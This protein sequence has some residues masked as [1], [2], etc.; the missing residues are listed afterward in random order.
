MSGSSWPGKRWS[1]SDSETARQIRRSRRR[2]PW[3]DRASGPGSDGPRGF[4]HRQRYRRQL[5]RQIVEHPART[6][7]AVTRSVRNRQDSIRPWSVTNGRRR[8][9]VASVR[10]GR[11]GRNGRRSVGAPIGL[12]ISQRVV[13]DGAPTPRIGRALAFRA[14]VHQV[15]AQ[16]AA[17][18][19]DDRLSS[20]SV[21]GTSSAPGGSR[22][23]RASNAAARFR[24]KVADLASKCFGTFIRPPTRGG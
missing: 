24:R 16:L 3:L 9:W 22:Y 4:V 15:G 23:S 2:S 8:Y 14:P 5:H 17:Q 13:R 21:P 12:A 6:A 1:R 11:S 20:A 7:S 10:T 19:D 18:V